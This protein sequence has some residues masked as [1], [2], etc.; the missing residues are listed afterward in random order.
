MMMSVVEQSAAAMRR[1]DALCSF[2]E[3]I[4]Q[5]ERQNPMSDRT[6]TNL[7]RVLDA[8]D[9]AKRKAFLARHAD[10]LGDLE[11]VAGLKYADF[12][13][14]A[15]YSVLYAQ[16]LNLDRSPP[17]DIL[18][19][20]MGSGNFVMV[21]NS[22]GHR[23]IGTDVDNPW[24]AELCEL[25]GSKRIVAPVTREDPYKPIDQRFDLITMMMPAFHRK[26]VKGQRQY[27][28]VEDWRILLLGLVENLLKPGGA[29]FILMTLD[30]DD[31]GNVGYSPLIEWARERG[32]RLGR[33]KEDGPIRHILFD[34]ATTGTFAKT[35]P[36]RES[37]PV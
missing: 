35:S 6:R 12:A 36:Q 20:G 23:A 11:T 22:M 30:K 13:Y 29:I 21:A 17:L 34:P 31:Q 27:W 32:A 1:H 18:D 14:W 7:Q 5:L 16:W 4:E 15:H 19:I 37:S 26:R 8:I 3:R 25:V 33:T 2:E 24:Y 28:S 9:A 10:Q